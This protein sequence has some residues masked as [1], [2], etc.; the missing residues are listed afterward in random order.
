M[1]ERPWARPWLL[2]A[3]LALSACPAS[4]G[5]DPDKTPSAPPPVSP[6]ATNAADITRFQDEIPLGPE[7]TIA[8]DGTVIRRS[9]E[10]GDPVATL[11]QGTR[12]VKVSAHGGQTLVVFEDPKTTG[13]RLMG[14][15]AE[16]ALDEA[17]PSPSPV[18]PLTD[19]GEGDG[20]VPPPPSPPSPNPTPSRHHRHHRP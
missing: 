12:V 3:M 11:G 20:D 9:P 6:W 5:R 4:R 10:P 18:P 17:T 14:W 1:F 2:S 16:M 13:Q 8:R 7:A 19:G 15:V